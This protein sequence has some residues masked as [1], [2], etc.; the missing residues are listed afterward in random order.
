MKSEEQQRI[1]WTQKNTR[2]HEQSQKE[3]GSNVEQTVQECHRGWFDSCV[4]T[5]HLQPPQVAAVH[6]CRLATS[7]SADTLRQSRVR[8]TSEP[9]T[10]CSFN[11]CNP[12][13]RPH[14]HAELLVMTPQMPLSERGFSHSHSTLE[15][16]EESIA[17]K[18]PILEGEGSEVTVTTARLKVCEFL[19]KMIDSSWPQ[20]NSKLSLH[21]TFQE[22]V[23]RWQIHQRS[24]FYVKDNLYYY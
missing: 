7:A 1:I 6:Q 20:N 9:K 4:L 23:F 15:E 10:D 24:V 16:S 3:W 21:L 8:I 13:A 19:T 18:R 12:P 11:Y 17:G 14:T 22:I 5:W 2:M